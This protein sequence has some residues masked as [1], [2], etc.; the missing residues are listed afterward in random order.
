MRRPESK[1]C[2]RQGFTLTEIMIVVTIIG[3]VLAIV[4]PSFIKAREEAHRQSCREAQTKLS[5]AIQQWAMANGAQSDAVPAD[6]TALIG[7]EAY[8]MR[9]PVC[10]IGD[11]PIELHAASAVSVCP[12]SIDSHEIEVN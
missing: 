1:R 8:I 4:V 11:V 12:N 7:A 9:T 10:P 3:I 5:G 6:Y 2:N